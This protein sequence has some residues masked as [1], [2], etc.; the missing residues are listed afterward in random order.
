MPSGVVKWLSDAIKD[1][2]SFFVGGGLF[3]FAVH[4]LV[5]AF[6]VRFAPRRSRMAHYSHWSVLIENIPAEGLFERASLP[7]PVATS[8]SLCF[9]GLAA[10]SF[11]CV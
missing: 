10:F 3:V 4:S 11:L 5:L 6:V 8:L 7:G 9:S 2:D 1:P